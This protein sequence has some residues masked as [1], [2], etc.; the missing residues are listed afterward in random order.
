MLNNEGR[1]L[2]AVTFWKAPSLALVLCC[3]HLTAQH[4]PTAIGIEVCQC[5]PGPRDLCP[6]AGRAF[7]LVTKHRRNGHAKYA[8]SAYISPRFINVGHIGSVMFCGA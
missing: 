3:H 8:F 4:M 7:P 1:G 6:I 2:A 5:V